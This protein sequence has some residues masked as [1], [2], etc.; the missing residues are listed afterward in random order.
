MQQICH[1]SLYMLKFSIC[2]GCACH[3]DNVRIQRKLFHVQKTSLQSASYFIAH[4]GFAAFFAHGKAHAHSIS[5][6]RQFDCQKLCCSGKISAIYARK[7]PVFF[8]GFYPHSCLCADFFSALSTA[9]LQH[10]AAVLSGH[11][12]AETVNLASLSLLRLISHLHLFVPLISI[13]IPRRCSD[14]QS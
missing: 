12:L 3:K 9:A 13:V 6:R 14:V 8:K 11:S 5:A 10:V 7:I 4:D 2:D 1:I